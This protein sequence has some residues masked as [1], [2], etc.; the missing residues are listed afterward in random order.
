M[1]IPILIPFDHLRID[2]ILSTPEE[3][4]VTKNFRLSVLSSMV[5][6][7][8]FLLWRTLKSTDGLEFDQ[9]IVFLLSFLFRS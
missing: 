3:R 8:Y 2:F 9:V 5:K 4:I 1:G 7:S 6:M